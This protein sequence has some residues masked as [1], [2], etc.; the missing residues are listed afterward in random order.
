MATLSIESI[1]EFYGNMSTN[2]SSNSTASPAVCIWPQDVPG[3]L[4][5]TMSAVLEGLPPW[6]PDSFVPASMSR[7]TLAFFI[8]VSQEERLSLLSRIFNL[9]YD[10]FD[11]YLYA[12]DDA[13]LSVGRVKDVLPR[14][15]PQNVAVVSSPHAGYYYWPRV[16]VLLNGLKALLSSQ[17]DFVIHLSESDYPLHSLDW[18][19]STIAAQRRHVFLK[20]HP[21]CKLDG[22]Q[23]IRSKWNWWG[24]DAAVASC[25]AAFTPHAVQGVKFPIEEM[26][27]QGF[28]F[29]SAAEWMIL[30]RE[31]VEYAM[32]PELDD[33]KRLVSM[34]AAADEVFWATLVLNVPDFSRTINPQ[35]WFMFRSPSNFGH[36][37]DTLMHKHLSMIMAARRENFFMRKVD[38]GRSQALL[39]MVDQVISEPDDAPGPG[40]AQWDSRQNAVPSCGWSTDDVDRPDPYWRPPAEP[41]IT[42]PFAAPAPPPESALL[43]VSGQAWT[44]DP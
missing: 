33:L 13:M 4:Q 21:H 25:E 41:K 15:L 24:E 1:G 34:H 35:T 44:L 27:G 23:L 43:V 22:G 39:D 6:P 40:Q 36:S 18:I 9:I 28:V 2:A 11:V 5:R 30:P 32:L 20:I 7:V 26:E 42:G 8:Q 3:T 38:E 29:A 10:P 16:Q 12:V 19:R 37:P 17:W 31:L 14:P